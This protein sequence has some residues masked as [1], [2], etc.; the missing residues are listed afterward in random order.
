VLFNW[1]YVYATRRRHAQIILGEPPKLAATPAALSSPLPEA[2]PLARERGA[3]N[4][5]RVH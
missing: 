1:A 5:Q 4:E 2:Q 3:A